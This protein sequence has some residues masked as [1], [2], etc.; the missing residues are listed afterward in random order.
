MMRSSG[1][2]SLLTVLK[3]KKKKKSKRE[4]ECEEKLHPRMVII[5]A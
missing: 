1:I 4:Q 5:P 2:Q 3:K